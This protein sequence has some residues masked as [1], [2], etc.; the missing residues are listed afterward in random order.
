VQILASAQ[1]CQCGSMVCARTCC[2][3]RVLTQVHHMIWELALS[4][5]SLFR[6]RTDLHLLG[7]AVCA[8]PQPHLRRG[9]Q[10]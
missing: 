6:C 8:V 4:T 1:R 9:C 7:L 10:Q 2:R 5:E 3:R